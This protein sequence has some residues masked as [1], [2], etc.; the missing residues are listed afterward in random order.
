MAGE[1]TERQTRR[2]HPSVPRGCDHVMSVD[3][4]VNQQ[5]LP[6]RQSVVDLAIAETSL[7]SLR[8]SN[9]TMLALKDLSQRKIERG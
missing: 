9:E 3:P 8:A 4:A 2:E 6:L 5:P 1:S 7:P